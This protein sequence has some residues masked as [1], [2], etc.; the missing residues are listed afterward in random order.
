MDNVIN[1]DGVVEMSKVF[2]DG[3]CCTRDKAGVLLN[4]RV[5]IRDA[6]VEVG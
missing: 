6:D 5:D 2:K 3:F 4:E 1:N